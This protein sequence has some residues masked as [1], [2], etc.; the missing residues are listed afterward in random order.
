[1]ADA[2]W[3]GF[4]SGDWDTVAGSGA[5]GTGTNWNPGL[6]PDG[7]ATFPS[8]A[9]N[10]HLFFSKAGLHALGTITF[11]G[12]L[13]YTFGLASGDILS[14]TG[15]GLVNALGQT[16][17]VGTNSSIQFQNAA[18]AD[19]ATF[20]TNANGIINFNNTSTAASS[21]ITVNSGA[22]S[23]GLLLFSNNSSAGN[24]T[25]TSNDALAVVKFQDNS[26]AAHSHI[27]VQNNGT[28]DFTNNSTAFGATINVAS[29]NVNFLDLSSGAQSTI[30]NSG[31]V[32]FFQN[33][34]DAAGSIDTKS[35]GLTVFRDFSYV[36]AVLIV[37]AGGTLD[38]SNHV[39]A[40][41]SGP[42]SGSG[43]II[44]GA[45]DLVITPNSA[46]TTD[47]YSGVASG[48]GGLEKMGVG[49]LQLTGANTYTG[50]TT[51]GGGILELAV[52]GSISGNVVFQNLAPA[53]G[54]GPTFKIDSSNQFHGSIGGLAGGDSVDLAFLSFASGDHVSFLENSSNTGGVLSI[55][56][57]G[58][59][60]KT[61]LNFLGM[62]TSSEFFVVT[63]GHGG[64][65]ISSNA[66]SSGNN[67]FS[68]GKGQTSFN[69]GGGHDRV[70]FHGPSAEY[71]ITSS[72]NG[73]ITV[74]DNGSAGD[75]TSTLIGIEDLAFSDK[76]I[77]V[78]N[79]DNANIAR[80][81]AAAFNRSPDVAGLDFWEDVYTNNVGTGAK[82]AGYYT[83]L[84]QTDD[85]SGMSIAA[86]FMQS[87]EFTNRY[88]TLTDT[89][90]VNALYQNVLGRLP[91]QSGLNFWLDQL[92]HGTSRAT[93]LVGFAE[94]PEN[95]LKT[96]S[97]WLIQV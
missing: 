65:L 55:L 26:S 76:T 71:T 19:A 4:V 78:E 34:S 44:L 62:H 2:T 28:L 48:T 15:T 39:G 75:G 83:A 97:D 3:D 94:S 68:L 12:G 73:V 40:V 23:P 6:V 87:S 89:G 85:G 41:A 67:T 32:T 81:Y 70:I 47:T 24:A 1:M 22:A 29:G 56:N 30:I 16:F 38:I 10:N 69:G 66:A 64:S 8:F 96:S 91:D 82:A 31:T 14:L 79:V 61:T 80:L 17:S 93:V 11:S 7:T 36:G 77:F 52:G 84:A 92:A 43:K 50:A 58:G 51:I 25:I 9:F 60:V 46:T 53:T 49:L 33:S 72:T 45:N 63:D 59:V 13:A 35:G 74:R 21:T 20:T 42:V 5:N 90:F 18:S 57:T 86:G 95:V 37:E 54:S 27:A 88:G